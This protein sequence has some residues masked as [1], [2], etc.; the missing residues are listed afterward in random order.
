[1]PGIDTTSVTAPEGKTTVDAELVFEP[2]RLSY[3]CADAIAA[4]ISERVRDAVKDKVVVVADSALLADCANLTAVAVILDSLRR[5][6]ESLAAL[7]ADLMAQKE[8]TTSSPRSVAFSV[9]PV[10]GLG[11]APTIAPVV[12]GI[13]TALGI[14]SLLREDVDYHGTK[15]V[16]DPAAFYLALAARLHASGAVK[17]LVPEFF[18]TRV[19]SSGPVSL[20]IS[21]EGVEQARAAVWRTVAPMISQLGRLNAE[22]DLAVNQ[23]DQEAVDALSAEL[24]A[25]RRDLDPVT[26]ALGRADQQL[27]DLKAEW[28]KPDPNS[29]V[30]N[31]GRLLRAEAIL[32]MNPLF[33]HAKVVMSGGHLRTVRSL[34]RTMFQGDGLSAMGGAV[35]RWALLANDGSVMDGGIASARQSARFPPAPR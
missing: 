13:E 21:L 5:D 33:V 30:T 35:A 27:G 3:L 6:Y 12:A 11:I 8:E 19:A 22:L 18:I 23:K 32:D 31:L 15:T 4:E 28:Q 14:V 20:K 9:V 16:V 26:E 24:A 7:A 1:M 10:L 29:G 2:E 17:V 25:M 34:W